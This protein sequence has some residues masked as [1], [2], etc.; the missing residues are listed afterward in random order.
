MLERLRL[1]WIAF[2]LAVCVYA[3]VPWFVAFEGL[4]SAAPSTVAL[5]SGLHAGALGTAVASFLVRR[6]CTHRLLAAMQPDAPPAG[7]LW[8][9][10]QTGSV[11]TWA[12]SEVVALI[13]VAIALVTRNPYDALPFAGA[14]L[15]LLYMHRLALWPVALIERTAGSRP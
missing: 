8:A 6:Q 7:D 14:A 2:F 1:I 10:L 11:L 13:G 3:L 5:R 12:I 9:Q 15:F 4:D